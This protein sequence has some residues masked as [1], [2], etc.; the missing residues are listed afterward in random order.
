M[1]HEQLVINP[2]GSPDTYLD[3]LSGNRCIRL[4]ALPGNLELTYSATVDLDHYRA[5]PQTLA[6][7]PVRNLPPAVIHFLYRSR[8]CESDRPSQRSSAHSDP[9]PR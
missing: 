7:V 1:T 4:H 2:A 9:T 3:P 5:A 8:Y 6:E